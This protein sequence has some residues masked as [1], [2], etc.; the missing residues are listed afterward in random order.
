[1]AV[2]A[3]AQRQLRTARVNLAPAFGLRQSSAALGPGGPSV[4]K[5]LGSFAGKRQRTGPVE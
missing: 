5:R 1:M 4:P 2:C 3:G